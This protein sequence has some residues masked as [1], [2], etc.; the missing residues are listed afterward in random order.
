MIVASFSPYWNPHQEGLRNRQRARQNLGRTLQP[1]SDY[2]TEKKL[3][4]SAVDVRGDR[5]RL[6]VDVQLV[7]A[8][9]N[10]LKFHHATRR[11][12]FDIVLRS[13]IFVK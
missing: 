2:S 7:A 13:L 6:C 3:K 8:N 12:S 5:S 10:G 11:I 9:Y 4:P 1:S